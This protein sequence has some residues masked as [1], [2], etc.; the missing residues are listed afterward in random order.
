MPF[1]FH[2]LSFEKISDYF[3]HILK[4]NVNAYSKSINRRWLSMQL[5]Q[6]YINKYNIDI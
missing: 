1:D 6:V 2:F 4:K 3:Y 5:K